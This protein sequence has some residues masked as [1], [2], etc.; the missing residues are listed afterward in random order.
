MPDLNIVHYRACNDLEYYQV[1]IDGSTAKYTVY[2]DHGK[3]H[4]DCKGF[5][6]RGKCKHV[7][8]AEKKRCSWTE[9]WSDRPVLNK[10]GKFYCPVCGGE[11]FVYRVG[12]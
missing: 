9:E 12:V 6:F 4:C 2:C 10:N 5:E 8:E 7:G 3:W 11:T 1:I